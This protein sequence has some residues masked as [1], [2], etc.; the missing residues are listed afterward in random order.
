MNPDNKTNNNQ[1]DKICLVC[2]T[3]QSFYTFTKCNHNQVCLHCTY[4]IRTFYSDKKC[5]LCALVN[6]IVIIYE[7]NKEN[8]DLNYALINQEECYK[9]QDYETN[10]ILYND[11]SAKEEILEQTSF[12]CPVSS[13][14]ENVFEELKN[15]VFHVKK[16]HKRYYCEVCLKDGKRFLADSILYNYDD[17]Q[18]HY[19]YGEYDEHW[20]IMAPIHPECQY[21]KIKFYSEDILMQ[22]VLKDHFECA[23]CKT[24]TNFVVFFKDVKALVSITLLLI[25]YNYYYHIS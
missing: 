25:F 2:S 10:G 18:K 20:N 1:E 21:C 12:K 19:K 16:Q 11:I 6:D 22:H 4:K 9:D 7:K 3:E 15:L 17:L 23:L 13:C 14:N 8:E 24:Q 5:P